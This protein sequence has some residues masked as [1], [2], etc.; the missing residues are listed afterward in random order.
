MG[1]L[2]FGWQNYGSSNG[3]TLAAHI[4]NTTPWDDAGQAG[5]APSNNTFGQGGTS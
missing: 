5:Q 1:V 3:A 2:V 4:L